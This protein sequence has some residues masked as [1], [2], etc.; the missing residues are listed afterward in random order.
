[1]SKN[2]VETILEFIAE[3]SADNGYPPSIREIQDK[4]AFKSTSTVSY[5]LDKLKNDGLITKSGRKNRAI[6]I[7]KSASA[8]KA[9]ASL[10]A[11]FNRIPLVGTITAGQPILATQSY[12]DVF[13]MPVNLFK[14]EDL[15]MLTV[16]GESM[17]DAGIFD[18]DKIVLRRQNTAVNG[19]IIAA[20]VDDSA[21]V[22]RFY[23]EDGQIRLQ[24]ENP[25]MQPMYFKSVDILGKV[26]GLIRKM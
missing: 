17:I 14:G 22:K 5:Y 9:N 2:K 26:V 12:D 8:P 1:M 10:P 16:S 13:Y 11:E 25:T 24:P 18:G 7:A 20:L 15:F 4:F 6:N 23:K 3:F 19:E 21:T